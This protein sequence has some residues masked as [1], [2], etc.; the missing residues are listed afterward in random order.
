MDLQKNIL[1]DIK[2]NQERLKYEK[3]QAERSLGFKEVAFIMMGSVFFYS[4]FC[5][6]KK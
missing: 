4:F 2:E 1:L 6:I 3:N 5:F